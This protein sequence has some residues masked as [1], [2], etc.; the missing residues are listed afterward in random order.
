MVVVNIPVSPVFRRVE[1]KPAKIF[2]RGRITVVGL[3]AADK[4]EPIHA[5][6]ADGLGKRG[7][8]ISDLLLHKDVVVKTGVAVGGSS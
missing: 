6:F 1:A 2:L 3:S 4:L 8:I 7:Q 5:V